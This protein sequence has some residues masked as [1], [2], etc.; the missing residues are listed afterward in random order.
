ME[1]NGQFSPFRGNFPL[2]PSYLAWKHTKGNK[3]ASSASSQDINSKKGNTTMLIATSDEI[4][5]KVLTW[6]DSIISD[7]KASAK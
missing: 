2:A 6:V 4:L 5:Q 3:I 1:A 7:S